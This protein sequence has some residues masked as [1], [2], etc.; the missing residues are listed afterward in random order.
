MA[1]TA[2]KFIFCERR[3]GDGEEVALASVCGGYSLPK[4]NATD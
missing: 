4:R 2:W 3:T 1:D